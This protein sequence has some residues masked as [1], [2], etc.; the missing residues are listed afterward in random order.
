[1]LALCSML[2]PTYYAKNYAGIMG[3]GLAHIRELYMLLYPNYEIEHF[4]Y[5]Y[6]KSKS[7]T[8]LGEAYESSPN[9]N[10]VFVAF[11]PSDV[12]LN[13]S[14]KICQ[15]IKFIKHKV[16]L[17]HTEIEISQEAVHIFCQ[18]R[19]FKDHSHKNWFGH[20]AFVCKNEQEEE[21]F[22][23]FIP[24]QRLIARCAFGNF[25]LSFD[26][27]EIETVFVTVPMP[28]HWYAHGTV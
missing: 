5:F 12:E 15:I 25:K 10:S 13:V 8:F 16:T 20:S 9:R 22:A 1:M 21:S 24:L 28:M 14:K 17:K 4:S 11:W 18:V 19:W 6:M 2:H 23:S 3:A 27:E 7:A 26:S